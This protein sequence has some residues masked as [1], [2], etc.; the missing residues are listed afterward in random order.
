MNL[1]LENY[2]ELKPIYKVVERDIIEWDKVKKAFEYCC[3]RLDTRP[4]DITIKEICKLIL[5][6]IK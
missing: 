2:K 5:D 3:I 6:S 4:D 1:D